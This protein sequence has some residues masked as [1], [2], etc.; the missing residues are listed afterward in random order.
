M[1][2]YL[3]GPVDY[4]KTLKLH[5]GVGDLHLLERGKSHTSSREEEEDAQ[6]HPLSLIHI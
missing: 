5:Y 2:T 3:H 4:V 1:N 6:M